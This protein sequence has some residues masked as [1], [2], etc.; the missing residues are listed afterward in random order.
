MN[1]KNRISKLEE[2]LCPAPVVPVHVMI[3]IP[4]CRMV[5]GRVYREDQFP[6]GSDRPLP[7]ALSCLPEL[8]SE[9]KDADGRVVQRCFLCSISENS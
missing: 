1:L 7:G 5:G 6:K 8:T 3:V 2:T 4:G 9:C